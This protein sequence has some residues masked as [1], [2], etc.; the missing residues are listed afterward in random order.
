MLS[1]SRNL[2]L[3]RFDGPNWACILLD[4]DC[5]FDWPDWLNW[6]GLES[7]ICSGRDSGGKLVGIG[8]HLWAFGLAQ[9]NR[10]GTLDGSGPCRVSLWNR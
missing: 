8:Y 4:L 2:G 9:N 1:S 5:I 6:T 3:K 10:L 7:V